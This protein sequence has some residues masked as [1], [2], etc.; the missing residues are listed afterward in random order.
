MFPCNLGSTCVFFEQLSRAPSLFHGNGLARHALNASRSKEK[1][2]VTVH[3]SI[4][5]GLVLAMASP[6]CVPPLLHAQTATESVGG[7]PTGLAVRV[8][9][10]PVID[11]L[12]NESLWNAASPMQGFVQHEP[13][14]GQPA[15][16]R[17]EVRILF[18]R[19]AIY[20]GARMFDNNPT[21]IRLGE[22]RRDAN[23]QD[24]DA[25]LLVFDTYLDRQNAFVFGTT[26]V[27]IEYDGQVTRD[28]QGGLSTARRTQAGAGSGGGF[29]LNWDGSWEV[30]TSTDDMGW[31]AEF[32][33]PFSTL[34]YRG[35]GEQV[36][37]LNMAR[38]IRRLNEEV[39]WA[40]I[41]RQHTL[42]RVSEAGTL[43]GLETPGRRYWSLTPYV[44]GSAH[45]DFDAVA[46]DST[47][48][49]G[50]V[51]FDSKIGVTSSLN[52]DLTYNT[53]FAQVEADEQQVNLTRFSLFFP[54][55]RPFFL[56]NA[57]LFSI[58]TPRAGTDLGLDLFYSRRIGIGGEGDLVPIVAGGR[59]TGK[60]GGFNVGMLSIQTDEVG[61]NGIPGNNY[62]VGRVLKELPNR[63]QVGAMVLSRLNTDSTSDYNLTFAAD[64][65]LGIGQ[66]I[67][68]DAYVSRTET[69][70]L[71]GR[72]HGLAFTG[73][74]QTREWDVWLQYREIGDN[75]NPE[76]GFLPRWGYRVFIERLERRFR[77]PS[78][79]WVRELR[80]HAVVRHFYDF[81]GFL[82]TRYVHLDNAT[83]FENGAFL[84]TA[85]NLH[86]EGL[87]EPFEIRDDIVIPTG[88]YNFTQA[89]IRFN[90][91]QSAAWS[92]NGIITVGGFYT[93]R[94]KGVSGTLTSRV[95]STWLAAL[96]ASYDN[97]DLA[98]GTFDTALLG[99]KL[100]YSFTPRIFVQSLMQ[101]S[102]DRD[103]VSVNARFGWLNTAGTGLYLV[104]NEIQRTIAPTGPVDRAF[105]LKY[106][107]QFDL[108]R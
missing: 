45:A 66:S 21:G 58:G 22:N 94:R 88:D 89:L 11:G 96:T 5:A 42:Y 59:L 30:A 99:L 24:A 50:E 49:A 14:E 102:T 27:G 29:N 56:E 107:Y 104:Y 93:G 4:L 13:D 34:R 31:C 48:W 40:P 105:I 8:D 38:M 86:H 91:N 70:S 74:Y 15:N 85:V 25:I 9:S 23:L 69:P 71:Q 97:V 39:F 57:G 18:D 103:R 28:G 51:G 3:R 41:A 44:L 87:K 32:R 63:S 84:S 80:P 101:Y 65:R 83:Q 90:T 72:E 2:Q 77:V 106:N 67:N 61:S 52:L 108:F 26:P 75:F 100:S 95:G 98:E 54:E 64:G 10:A 17:T 46:F 78:I 20:V 68:L 79:G 7:T 53:D 82:E 37:G 81:D 35:G 92:V 76:V 73:S 36:W 62:S 12:L 33:I 43:Q 55:K 6:V 16:E 47:D 60:A 1:P 19:G